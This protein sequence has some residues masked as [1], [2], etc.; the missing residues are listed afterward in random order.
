[1]AKQSSSDNTGNKPLCLC[2]VIVLDLIILL[3]TPVIIAYQYIQSYSYDSDATGVYTSRK[4]DRKC[5][6]LNPFLI[7]LIEI[8]QRR[9]TGPGW[10]SQNDKAI[11]AFWMLSHKAFFPPL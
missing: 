10:L 7:A 4:T 5:G 6:P 9:N 1:M 11:Y 2:P 3:F 8:R